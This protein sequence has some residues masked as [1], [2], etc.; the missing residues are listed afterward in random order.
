[1]LVMI[2]HARFF[3]DIYGLV[4]PVGCTKLKKTPKHC[5]FLFQ[6]IFQLNL[7][8]GLSSRGTKGIMRL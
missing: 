5:I 6:N 2:M 3:L 7:G 1:M 4:L 8:T